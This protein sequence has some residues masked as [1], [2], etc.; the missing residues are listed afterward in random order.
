MYRCENCGCK[1][2][3]PKQGFEAYPDFGGHGT[4]YCPICG[5]AEMFDEIKTEDDEDE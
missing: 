2:E 4:E 5:A 1:F 3:T